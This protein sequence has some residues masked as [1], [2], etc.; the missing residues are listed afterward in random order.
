MQNYI[1]I[2]LSFN[3]FVFILNLIILVFSKQIL[4]Y[5]DTSDLEWKQMSEKEME[6][7]KKK[8][9]FLLIINLLI[10]L[11]YSIS[12][13]L[14]LEAINTIIKI[15]VVILFSFMVSWLLVRWVVAIY[16][17][18]V[19]INWE[20][21]IKKGYKTNIFSILAVVLVIV[22]TF[23]VIVDI[24]WFQEW[25]QS[26]W[27]IGWLLAFLWFTAPVWATDMFSSILLLHSG[28][29]DLWDVVEFNYNGQKTVAFIKYITLSEVM[30]V[31]L[32]YSTPIILRASEFRNLGIKNWSRNISLS[33]SKN[34]TQIIE[35]KIS[36]DIN[37]KQMKELFDYTIDIML[38][39][40]KDTEYEKYFPSNLKWKINVQI[41][42]FGDFAVVY[43][44]I[45]E[46]TNPFYIIRANRL[47]N[48]YLQKAQKKFNIEFSTPEL[49]VGTRI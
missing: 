15:L 29:V 30:L 37:L 47:L 48:V 33:K 34:I 23:Y 10:F 14:K 4:I 42:D 39:D 38:Q 43:Q 20:T 9:K 24:A 49:F 19:E 32:V 16:W 22:I 12:L 40:I 18:K 21:Y 3:T 13:F 1:D 17:E 41:K 7:L 35:A 8:R 36:Y 26:G 6:S 5:L 31:D 28:K 44:L 11:W 2:L 25:L 45:Y 27:F 46:I